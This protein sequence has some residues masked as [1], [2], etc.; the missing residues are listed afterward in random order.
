MPM[1][2]ERSRNAPAGRRPTCP[3]RHRF[4]VTGI[5]TCAELNPDSPIAFSTGLW[6]DGVG[7]ATVTQTALTVGVSPVPEP[8]TYGMLGAGLAVLALARRRRRD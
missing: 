1:Y 5:E 3:C 7:N 6:F 2:G 8:A 4:R